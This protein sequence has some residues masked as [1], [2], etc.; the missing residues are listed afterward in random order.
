[1]NQQGCSAP[2][3]SVTS[4]GCAASLKLEKG[5]GKALPINQL[6]RALRISRSLHVNLRGEIVNFAKIV[7]S[8]LHVS[9]TYVFFKTV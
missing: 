9:P 7:S 6:L 1:M 2:R 4:Q 5:K 8:Q 3:R